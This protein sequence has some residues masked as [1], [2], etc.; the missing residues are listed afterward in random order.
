MVRSAAFW[1]ISEFL[2][3]SQRQSKKLMLKKVNLLKVNPLSRNSPGSREVQ[4]RGK[5]G[6][7]RH[8]SRKM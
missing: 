8:K 1:A 3:P 7:M 4:R 6:L 5:Q 2:A